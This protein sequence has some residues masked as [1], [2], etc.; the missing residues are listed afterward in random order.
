MTR[1]RHTISVLLGIVLLPLLFSVLA[2]LRL[3]DTFLEPGF[4]PDQLEKADVYEFV[5]IDVLTSAL[6]EARALDPEELGMDLDENPL[7]A[8]GLTTHQIVSAVN[9]VLP[10]ELLEEVGAPIALQAGEYIA[11]ERDE[12]TVAART[13]DYFEALVE[14]IEQLLAETDAY[15]LL[16]EEELEPRIKESATEALTANE[17]AAP[18]MLG[19]FGSPEDV[20]DTL[21]RLIDSVLTP[22]WVQEQVESALDEVT[23]YMVS[24]SDSFEIRIHL[25]DEEVNE[26]VEEAK[27]ILREADTHGLLLEQEIEPR[28]REAA[29][30]AMAADPDV[31]RW[32][33][34]L[35]GTGEEAADRL[36]QAIGRVVTPEWVQAQIESALDKVPP[37]LV[38]KSHSFELAVRLTDDQ[39]GAAVEE[40]KAILHET[41]AYDLIY[42]EVI[43]PAVRDSLGGTIVLPYGVEIAKDEVVDVLR[44]AAPT[45]WVRQETEILIAEVASYI[46]GRT[47]GFSTTVSL[48]ANKLQAEVAFENLL[49]AKLTEIVFDLP[50][51]RTRAEA[52]AA[53]DSL[54]LGLPSCIPAGISAGNIVEQALPDLSGSIRPLVLDPLPNR[55]WFTDSNLRLGVQETG[56]QQ[57]LDLLDES[58]ALLGEGWTYD[59]DDLRTALGRSSDGVDI[60]DKTRGILTDGYTYTHEDLREYLDG[61]D[62]DAVETLDDVRAFLA[63]DYVYTQEYGHGNDA[64]SS[65]RATLDAA[66]GWSAATRRYGWTAYLT[67]PVLL[68]GIG[69]LGGRSWRVRIAR[70]SLSLLVAAGLILIVFWP[71]YDAF[72]GAAFE[73]A[74]GDVAAQLGLGG[75]FEVTSLLIADKVVEVAESAMGEFVG[76]IRWS[77]F[78]LMAAASITL[79]TSMLWPRIAITLDRLGNT[80]GI[81]RNMGSVTN[82]VWCA[83]LFSR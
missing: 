18:W 15:D 55:V 71:I 21:T 16:L 68:I 2:L 62:D 79:L 44:Q 22:E 69:L 31:S 27:A 7:A 26:V 4:Y 46:A 39:V 35:F 73:A 8:S 76:G 66:H 6:D 53:S 74:R 20:D 37:Y 65:I 30:E 25:T 42:R 67:M 64:D 23:P 63:D 38:G 19:L 77:S 72:V 75:G 52:S 47:D 56:G 41:D 11:A 61:I 57:A 28:V 5:M 70:V 83:Q 12:L 29:D 49:E 36:T 17:D 24:E 10:P 48:A 50:A 78:I 32:T 59:S 45:V 51:C 58:R 33:M 81:G 1:V 34:Q 80:A 54:K 9:R 3:N 14:E 40:I 43:E 82:A 13:G 60:L